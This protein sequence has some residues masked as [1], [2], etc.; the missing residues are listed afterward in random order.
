[1][2]WREMIVLWLAAG[3]VLLLPLV[4]RGFRRK[5][6]GTCFYPE[7]RC[8]CAETAYCE[9]PEWWKWRWTQDG[10]LRKCKVCNAVQYGGEDHDGG[11]NERGVV[12]A[13]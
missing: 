2:A 4:L 6:C 5:L 8:T 11:P 1:M 12:Q 13:G 10:W 7:H 9:H 3:I